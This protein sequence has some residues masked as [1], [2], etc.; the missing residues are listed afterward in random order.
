MSEPAEKFDVTDIEES[1]QD[2]HSAVTLHCD[3]CQDAILPADPI[4]R[5]STM[6]GGIRW[7]FSDHLCL[8]CADHYEKPLTKLSRPCEQCGRAVF[9]V[10]GKHHRR[11]LCSKR[12]ENLFYRKKRRALRLINQNIHL[13]ICATCNQQFTASRTD[14]QHCSAACKQKAYRQRKGAM[15]EARI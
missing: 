12:C 15:I 3:T 5:H 1:A 8:S 14:Q 6:F 2:Y 10:K 4:L 11:V 13:C 9:Y 7:F